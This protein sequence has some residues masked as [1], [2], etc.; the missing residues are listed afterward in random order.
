MSSRVGSASQT[1]IESGRPL[2]QSWMME[3][4][5]AVQSAAR[6]FAEAGVLAACVEVTAEL[7]AQD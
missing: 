7:L 1:A 3:Q 6:A 4:S 2:F 5:D